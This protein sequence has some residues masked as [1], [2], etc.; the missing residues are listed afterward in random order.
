MKP[1]KLYV[2]VT[3]EDGTFLLRGMASQKKTRE[4]LTDFAEQRPGGR[5]VFT[6]LSQHDGRMRLRPSA[7]EL[8]EAEVIGRVAHAPALWGLLKAK[9]EIAP[10]IIMPS[11]PKFR[12]PDRSVT[13][14]PKAAINNGVAAVK[15]VRRIASAN[16]MACLLFCKPPR[17]AKAYTV[18]NKCVARQNEE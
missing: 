4:V 12:T 3:R 10:M 2:S 16:P 9:P 18:M 17:M 7:P 6:L 11:T 1:A 8:F 14:S 15:M 5:A 13:N